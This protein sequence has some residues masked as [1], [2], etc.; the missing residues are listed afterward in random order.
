[1]TNRHQQPARLSVFSNIEF[2]LWDAQDDATN[3]QRNLNIGDFNDDPLWLI[4]SVAAYL[5]ETG[6]RSI[7]DEPVVYDSRPGTE[8]PLYK[9][10]K[11]SLRWQSLKG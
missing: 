1:M 10:L 4:L 9:H 3:F 5:K 8:Q 11:R 7:L 6:D 2:C